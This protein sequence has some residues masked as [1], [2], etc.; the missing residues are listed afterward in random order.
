MSSAYQQ[1]PPFCIQVEFTEGCNLACTF[2]GIN[3]IRE[4]GGGPYHFMTQEIA[5][6]VA[7]SI[8]TAGWSARIEFAMHGEPTMNP[9]FN[10]LVQIF[11]Q[12][13]P[14][15]QLMMTSNG[16]GFLK[17]THERIQALF[18]AGLNVLAL[19]DYQTVN[20]VPRV[21]ERCQGL[22]PIHDYPKDGLQFS[23]HKRWA[24]D[25]R[26]I[27]IIE[28]I[29][30]ASSGNHATLTNHCGCGAPPNTTKEGQRCAKP[31][32]EIGIRWDGHMAGC[33]NDWRGVFKVGSVANTSIADLWQSPTMHAMRKKLYVGQR[34]FGACAGCDFVSYRNGLLPDKF[35][36]RQM[37]SPD[38]EDAV[39]I[40]EA[41]GGASYAATVK[42]PWELV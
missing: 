13:L 23:P 9:Q 15:N 14:H 18:Q 27:V 37:D 24:K 22:I 10:E 1:E 31:F 21:R 20:I 17:D 5:R 25:A 34:D 6:A 16:A 36:K 12:A 42:R 19:D 26:A 35:G 39:L 32:R 40:R 8:A 38:V 11:R 30:Q 29:E 4:K 2:C 3:G 33:C 41:T 28:D 7:R